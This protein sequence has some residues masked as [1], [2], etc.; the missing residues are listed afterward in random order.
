MKKIVLFILISSIGFTAF[1]QTKQFDPFVSVYKMRKPE[2]RKKV[3]YIGGGDYHDDLRKA[4]I[5]RKLLEVDHNYY[6][7]YTEDYDVFLKNIN[8]YDLLLINTKINF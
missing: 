2:G 6:V 8:N 1:A 3:L 7:T 4:A 5:L